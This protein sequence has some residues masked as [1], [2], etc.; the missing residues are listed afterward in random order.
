MTWWTRHDTS[1]PDLSDAEDEDDVQAT[2]E[3]N[4]TTKEPIKN[5]EMTVED[6]TAVQEGKTCK[7]NAIYIKIF[8]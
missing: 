2:K 8:S 7:S 6:G 1:E 5:E 3:D 4:T